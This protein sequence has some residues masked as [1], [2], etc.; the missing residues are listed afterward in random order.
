MPASAA[1]AADEVVTEWSFP[2]EMEAFRALL[3]GV[4]EANAIRMRLS[5]EV[6]DSSNVIK[7]LVIRA[8]DARMLGDMAEMRRHYSQLMSLNSEMLA[9]HAKRQTNHQRLLEA[10]RQVNAMIQ[11]VA[12]LRIGHGKTLFI[13]AC[14]NAMKLNNTEAVF[15]IVST[16]NLAPGLVASTIAR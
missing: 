15:A 6:A 11:K 1:S 2:L 3:H 12:R 8:E 9:E 4:D 5:A 14:R 13:N 10:L 7:A 16:G